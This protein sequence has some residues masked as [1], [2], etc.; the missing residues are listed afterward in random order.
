MITN[1]AHDGPFA[2]RGGCPGYPMCERRLGDTFLSFSARSS[3]M[4]CSSVVGD[5]LQL[6]LSKQNADGH[7]DTAHSHEGAL[8]FT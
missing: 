2:G 6:L 3:S 1:T 7:Q 4:L 5:I 8:P